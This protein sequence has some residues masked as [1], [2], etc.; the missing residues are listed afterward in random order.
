MGCGCWI[1]E[2]IEVSWDIADIHAIHTDQDI[3]FSIV[4]GGGGVFGC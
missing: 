1:E 3:C 4:E 2:T